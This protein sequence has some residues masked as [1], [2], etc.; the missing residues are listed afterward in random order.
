MVRSARH[1]DTG[2]PLG[3]SRFAAQRDSVLNEFELICRQFNGRL[4]VRFQTEL[5]P[6]ESSSPQADGA[7]IFLHYPVYFVRAKVEP[8]HVADVKHS[9]LS[10]GFLSTYPH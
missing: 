4:M 9:F 10:H 2:P 1:C 6:I 5:N 8:D 3:S 7:A